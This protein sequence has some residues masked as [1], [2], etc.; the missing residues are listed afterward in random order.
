MKSDDWSR[1]FA[2]VRE[3][4]LVLIDHLDESGRRRWAATEAKQIGWG[5]VSLVSR[6]A[7]ISERTIR[8]GLQEL[9][10]SSI[11]EP[12]L[13]ASRKAGGGRK[14]LEEEDENL[15][16]SLD[17]LIASLTRGDPFSPLRWTVASTRTL[18][19]ELNNRGF[20]ISASSVRKL[21]KKMGY[22]LQANRKTLEGTRHPD[23]NAKF[24]HIAK[25][26]KSTKR[27]KC[28]AVSVDTK[29]KEIFGPKKI[30]G[31]SW[32]PKSSGLAPNLVVDRF[33]F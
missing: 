21:L 6:A 26:V 32:G 4:Y 3:L 29:K 18:A 28:P 16:K 7:E 10:N 27:S 9:D 15:V 23:R 13:V 31:T 24:E 8:R 25:R 19:S 22:S 17:A 2:R 14:S 12:L 33:I 1:Q 30:V 5:G 20:Q 11:E